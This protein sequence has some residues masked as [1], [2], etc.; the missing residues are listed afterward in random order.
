MLNFIVKEIQ[1]S[2]FS[3][4]SL[5]NA[6]SL[7]TP[8]TG[9]VFWELPYTVSGITHYNNLSFCNFRV[10][11]KLFICIPLVFAIPYL[12][13]CLIQTCEHTNMFTWP[14]LAEQEN[15]K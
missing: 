10:F 14:C 1:V 11:L 15:E 2:H 13:V 5:A 8:I 3:P 7:K 6:K 4:T 9:Q 12:E